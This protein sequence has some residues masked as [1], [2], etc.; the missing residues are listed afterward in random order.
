MIGNFLRCC[1]F[2][3]VQEGGFCNV[4]GDPGGATNHG[5]TIGELSSVL[6]RPATV[7]DVM[8]LTDRQAESIYLPHYWRPVNADNL[9]AGVDLMVFDFGINA[10]PGRSAMRLQAL[11]GFNQLDG[12][13]GP[14]TIAAMAGRPPK[15]LVAELAYSHETYYRGLAGFAQFGDGWLARNTRAQAFA[16]GM[17]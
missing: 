4:Q 3:L 12:Q 14:A 2:S 11:L 9:P 16:T 1:G 13:I 10:G 6:G 7:Q 15:M 17:V 8:N 5:I